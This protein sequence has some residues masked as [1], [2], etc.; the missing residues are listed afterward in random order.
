MAS[1]EAPAMIF[2][3]MIDPML[4]ASTI[5]PVITKVC[6]SRF[7]PSR[8]RNKCFR[9]STCALDHS[10]R[11]E[12]ATLSAIEML[13][14]EHGAPLLCKCRSR[15]MRPY[16]HGPHRFD[17]DAGLRPFQHGRAAP[18]LRRCEIL[19]NHFPRIV[20]CDAAQEVVR[21]HLSPPRA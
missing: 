13:Q 11:A 17:S 3:S 7:V 10:H 18:A 5:C 15:S 19:G 1:V 21:K 9:L 8:V 20:F 16:R 12:S 2:Q 14:A 4:L 6:R